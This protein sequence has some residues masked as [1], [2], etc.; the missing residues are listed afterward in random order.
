MTRLMTFVS[1]PPSASVETHPLSP[2][3]GFLATALSQTFTV[4]TKNAMYKQKNAISL[5]ATW[6]HRAI[7]FSSRRR[8]LY[9]SSEK[10][11]KQKKTKNMSVVCALKKL[12]SLEIC[13]S[14]VGAGCRPAGAQPSDAAHTMWIGLSCARHPD[15]PHT[16]NPTPA[17]AKSFVCVQ[18]EQVVCANKINCSHISDLKYILYARACVCACSR[19]AR[20][21]CFLS[22][23]AS[24]FESIG[25]SV[26]MQ[27][28][29]VTRSVIRLHYYRFPSVQSCL[30]KLV[31]FI[32]CLPAHLINKHFVVW[33]LWSFDV[34]FSSR[35]KNATWLTVASPG[36]THIPPPPCCV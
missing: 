29:Y 14:C 26:W 13:V 3:F 25:G 9:P 20:A 18:K 6:R 30:G 10:A 19:C 8:K 7:C 1:V 32:S 36:E 34:K 4:M 15:A 11:N 16:V 12:R 5:R 35:L 28:L 31:I 33:E 23:C 27:S 2:L 21:G 22:L 24:A 17:N